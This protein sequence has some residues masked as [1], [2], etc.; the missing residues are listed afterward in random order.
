[1]SLEL[2][3]A[4]GRSTTRHSASANEARACHMI[5]ECQKDMEAELLVRG[6]GKKQTSRGKY[7][8]DSAE[9]LHRRS[10]DETQIMEDGERTKEGYRQPEQEVVW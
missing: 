5:F 2:R 3:T 1:M 6:K 9:L 8:A 4:T 10:A 7:T